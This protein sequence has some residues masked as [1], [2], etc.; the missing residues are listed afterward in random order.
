MSNLVLVHIDENSV[1]KGAILKNETRKRANSR[2]CKTIITP[3][4][5]LVKV[6]VELIIFQKLRLRKRR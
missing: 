4:P 3:V 5:G 2:S 6:A 1:H